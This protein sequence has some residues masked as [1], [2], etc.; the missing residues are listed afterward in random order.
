[1]IAALPAKAPATTA[2]PREVLVLGRAAGWAHSSRPLAAATITEMGKKTGAWTTDTTYDAAAF[3]A[4]NLKQ[5]DAIFLASTTGEVLNHPNDAAATAARKRAHEDL[6]WCRR[7]QH[8]GN[9]HGHQPVPPEQAEAAVDLRLA[10]PPPERRFAAF[11][12]NGVEDEAS[13]RGAKGGRSAVEHPVLWMLN[14]QRDDKRV[15]DLR[16]RQERR[17]EERDDR[18][19]WCPKAFGKWKQPRCD[20]LQE[21]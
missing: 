12:S 5:Y 14:R 7:R 11:P 17:I 13:G 21:F 9:D 10:E 4:D 20:L 15:T 6:E 18:E 3:T 16:Q 2:K 19:S 1:M 8:G